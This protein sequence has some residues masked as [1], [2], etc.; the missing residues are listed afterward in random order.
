MTTTQ[1][2][3]IK[4]RCAFGKEG[5]LRGIAVLDESGSPIAYA[6]INRQHPNGEASKNAT[7]I[8]NAP[9]LLAS[10]QMIMNA[11]HDES[12]MDDALK[13]AEETLSTVSQ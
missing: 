5:K 11:T 1:G 7:L 4:Q 9:R 6:I 2:E 8:A 13:Y 3:W 10:L 12:Y